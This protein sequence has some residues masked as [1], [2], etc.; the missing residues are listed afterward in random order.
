MKILLQDKH[1]QLYLAPNG[2]WTRQSSEAVD[3]PNYDKA[4]EFALRNELAEVQVILK[5]PDQRYHIRLPFRK[6]VFQAMPSL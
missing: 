3:F 5:F 2:Q 1:T 6:P 4:T